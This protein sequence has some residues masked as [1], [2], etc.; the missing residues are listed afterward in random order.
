MNPFRVVENTLRS[1]IEKV[2]NVNKYFPSIDYTKSIDGFFLDIKSPPWLK[3]IKMQKAGM[4]AK[5]DLKHPDL[6][7]SEPKDHKN[8]CFYR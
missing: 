1:F 8:R 3:K 6:F 2:E 7:C 4:C 5:S